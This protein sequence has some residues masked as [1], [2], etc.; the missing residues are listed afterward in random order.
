MA[1]QSLRRKS[2]GNDAELAVVSFAT[3]L[4]EGFS[5]IQVSRP[6]VE[7]TAMLAEN[8]VALASAPVFFTSGI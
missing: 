1:L 5:Q 8:G 2:G 6:R 3:L 4:A 7:M